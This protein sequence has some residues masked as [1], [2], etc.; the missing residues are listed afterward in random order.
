MTPTMQLTPDETAM[1]DINEGNNTTQHT[2]TDN[3][4]V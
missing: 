3:K 1:V 2:H 4:K